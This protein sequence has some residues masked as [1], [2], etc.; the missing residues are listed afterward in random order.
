MAEGGT[1]FLDEI[2]DLPL[3]IQPKLLRMLENKTIEPLGSN[4]PVKIR[5]RIVCA[6][7]RNLEQLV[8]E[9]KFRR[10]LF[11]RINTFHLELPPL[12]KRR[13]DIAPLAEYFLDTFVVDFGLDERYL[14]DAALRALES[15]HWPGKC[16]G[17]EECN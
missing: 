11:Y 13:E 17:A 9:G 15:Y 16:P 4:R 14:T 12:R 5:T 6:T 8:E 1:L 10:D 7:N 2:G 3:S